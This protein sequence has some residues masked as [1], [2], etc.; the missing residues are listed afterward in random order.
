MN[1]INL[2][3]RPLT[4]IDVIVVVWALFA[5]ADVIRAVTALVTALK[6]P[7]ARKRK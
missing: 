2:S 1:P 7:A 4:M 3:T 5:I 6:K